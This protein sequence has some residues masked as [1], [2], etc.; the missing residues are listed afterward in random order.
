MKKSSVLFEDLVKILKKLRGPK[1]CAWDKK[2]THETLIKNLREECEEV[3]T[4]IQNKDDENLCEELGDVLLQVVFHAVIATEQKRFTLS[5]VINNL[6]KKLVRR[7]P[8]VFG[9]AKANTPEEALALWKAT[10]VK[11]KLLLAKKQAK[12]QNKK[13]AK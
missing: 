2:Q 13:L 10:K 4:A 6:N 1:G 5:Q 12:K 11:E 3:I 8:H 7:H 9:K